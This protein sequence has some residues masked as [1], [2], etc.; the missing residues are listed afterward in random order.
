MIVYGN[1]DA[2]IET[3]AINECSVSGRVLRISTSSSPASQAIGIMLLRLLLILPAITLSKCLPNSVKIM[4]GTIN[5]VLDSANHVQRFLGI[6]Y[7]NP[8][9]DDLRLRQAQPLSEH[10]GTLDAGKFGHSCYGSADQNEGASEDCLTLNVWRP[11]TTSRQAL[12]VLV[13]LYGGGL[14]AGYTA[15][16]PG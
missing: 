14:T 5:G 13:W 16:R 12:P 2:A 7:A 15:S 9:V 11:A 1:F 6:P 10:F 3:P 4:N 8:P